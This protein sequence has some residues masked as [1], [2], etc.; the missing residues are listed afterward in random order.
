M[1]ARVAS[2]ENNDPSVFDDL[3]S[4]VR[5]RA[6]SGEGPPGAVAGVMLLD[7]E[8]RR[9]LGVTF[10]ESEDAIREAEPAFERMGDEIPESMRGRRT[11]METYE[12][13]IYDVDEEPK[14]ARLSSLEGDPSRVD[15]D[16]RFLRD[17]VVPEVRKIRGSKGVVGLIDRSSGRGK[18]ITFWESGDAL[19]ASEEQA[20]RLRR[21]AAEG[22]RS[23]IAGVE[24]YEVPWSIRLETARV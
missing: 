13:T 7:R 23:R 12:V 5:E 11:G 16:I 22:T 3:V 15:E 1:Y 21:Q 4:R 2:F 9:S 24:R 6:G 17:S 20:N 14:A 10:F 19:R 18:T 8:G